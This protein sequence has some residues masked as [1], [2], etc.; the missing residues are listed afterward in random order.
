MSVR[1]TPV[2]GLGAAV[3]ASGGRGTGM[4]EFLMALLLL[5]V[6]V[7][8][9]LAAHGTA[10]VANRHAAQ[11][12]QATWLARDMLERIRINAAGLPAYLGTDIGDPGGPFSMPAVDCSVTSCTSRQL[13]NFDLWQWQADLL[14][15]A[16]R[17]LGSSVGGL[18]DARGC[19]EHNGDTL[20]VAVSW[21][22]S[23]RVG[24]GRAVSCTPG[25]GETGTIR[26][27]V[28]LVSRLLVR[29]Q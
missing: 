17:Y 16:E 29:P 15:A 7:L 8:G 22:V 5:S 25:S 18:P 3:R 4:V 1:L 13:V 9:L 10:S 14:G 28:A 19:I 21:L 2:G 26:R 24:P 12:V 6:V 20:T 27:E 11:V 23:A